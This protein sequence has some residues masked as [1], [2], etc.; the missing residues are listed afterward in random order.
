[1]PVTDGE[2]S[3]P[4]RTDV[5]QVTT[6]RDRLGYTIAEL[7]AEAGVDPD[8]LSDLEAGRRRP[9]VSTLNKVLAALDRLEKEVGLDASSLP[10]GARSIGNPEDDLVEFSIEG[11]FGV[12]AVV[13]GPVRDL[14]ALQAAVAK[15]IAG[16]QAE[17][18]L[19]GE[20]P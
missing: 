17:G 20:Q 5:G 11:N 12:R 13:K 7:A 14:D 1:M 18:D 16:M 19:K 15:L 2:Q 6:R 10:P 8:T 3:V 9:Q 4:M